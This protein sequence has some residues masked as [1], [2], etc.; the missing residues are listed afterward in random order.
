MSHAYLTP[1][2]GPAA[3][4][5]QSLWGWRVTGIGLGSAGPYQ[6]VSFIFIR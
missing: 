3:A 4:A 1:V 2:P 5:A 6:G